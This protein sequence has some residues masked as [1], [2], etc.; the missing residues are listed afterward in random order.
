MKAKS[1]NNNYEIISDVVKKFPQSKKEKPSRI[2]NNSSAKETVFEIKQSEN[3]S[4]TNYEKITMK[5]YRTRHEFFMR[6]FKPTKAKLLFLYA[7]EAINSRNEQRHMP[8]RRTWRCSVY[9]MITPISTRVNR[10]KRADVYKSH[11]RLKSVG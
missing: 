4:C 3:V 7:Q 2:I 6:L 5:R 9:E 11:R 8:L 1:K 10:I